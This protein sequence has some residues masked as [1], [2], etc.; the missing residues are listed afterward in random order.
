MM[1]CQELCR[2]TD[3]G[4][5]PRSIPNLLRLLWKFE[6]PRGI[7]LQGLVGGGWHLRGVDSSL[8]DLSFRSYTPPPSDPSFRLC[9]LGQKKVNFFRSECRELCRETD[10]GASPRSIS[11]V[12]RLLFKF[13]VPRGI[14]LQGLVGGGWHL[15]GVDSSL[16][17]LSFRSYTPPPSEPSFRLCILGNGV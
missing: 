5:C 6:V 1:E 12:V 9:I 3:F 15:R 11:N 2:E 14:T 10:F 16:R 8:R 4:A 13:E 17:D 7:T